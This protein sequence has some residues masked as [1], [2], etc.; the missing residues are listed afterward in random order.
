MTAQDLIKQ[1]QNIDSTA[2]IIIL[3]NDKYYAVDSVFPVENG[4]YAHTILKDSVENKIY[5]ENH[6]TP[7]LVITSLCHLF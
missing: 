4:E 7:F 2:E 1:L 5:K 3:S 6:Q